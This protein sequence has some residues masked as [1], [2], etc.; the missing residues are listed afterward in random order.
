MPDYIRFR[1][2]LERITQRIEHGRELTEVVLRPVRHDPAFQTPN[3]E[4]P[5]FPI[6]TTNPVTTQFLKDTP[7]CEEFYVTLT[8]VI[9]QIVEPDDVEEMPRRLHGGLISTATGIT[10]VGN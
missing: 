1:Y 10:Q 4:N 3:G 9:P 5:P 2:H 8:R 7:L 6:Q